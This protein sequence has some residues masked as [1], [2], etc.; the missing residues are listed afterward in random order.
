LSAFAGIYDLAKSCAAQHGGENPSAVM[1]GIWL[2]GKQVIWFEGNVMVSVGFSNPGTVSRTQLT[3]QRDF[4]AEGGVAKIYEIAYGDRPSQRIGFFKDIMMF[5]PIIS[6]N[7]IDFEFSKRCHN[8]AELL[9]WVKK[10][11]ELHD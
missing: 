10:V 3:F 1:K 5:D 11:A 9:D 4:P 7:Q 6:D 2:A 8:E